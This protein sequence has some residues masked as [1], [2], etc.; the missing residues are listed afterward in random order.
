MRRGECV[1]LGQ[2]S[3]R[4]PTRASRWAAPRPGRSRAAIKR[5]LSPVRLPRP[6][7]APM[8]TR[9][10]VSPTPCAVWRG[11]ERWQERTHAM[12][13]SC[14]EGACRAWPEGAPAPPTISAFQ[15]TNRGPPP[16]LPPGS[17]SSASASGWTACSARTS[18]REGVRSSGRRKDGVL[19]VACS[20][21]RQAGR[22]ARQAQTQATVRQQS[23]FDTH[24]RRS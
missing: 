21:H 13:A 10:N 8:G 3:D 16:N 2:G 9:S 24:R 5:L 14:K 23:W 19:T 18:L 6:Y 4:T 20:P 17:P 7:Q 15:W 12:R 1:E 22:Q 11:R